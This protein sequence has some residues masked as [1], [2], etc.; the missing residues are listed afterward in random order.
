[1][2]FG[3]LDLIRRSKALFE[4]VIVAVA[5]NREKECLFSVPERVEMLEA[6]TQ[7]IPNLRVTSFSGL[8][9]EF[10]REQKAVALIRGLRVISDFEFEL[11][12]AITNRKMNPDVDT[13]CLMPSEKH[14][15]LS[16]RLVRDIA[17]HGG[18]VSEFV[19]PEIEARLIAKVG[20]GK[21]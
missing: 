8:T 20:E 6:V 11:V 16:S 14:W 1:P 9:A 19:P 3:H 21:G 12:M 10:S 2:T 5:H 13:V 17:Q 4:H 15:L 7:G 18:D